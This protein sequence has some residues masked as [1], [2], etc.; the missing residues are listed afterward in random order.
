M[1][2][3]DNIWPKVTLGEFNAIKTIIDQLESERD[4]LKEKLHIANGWGELCKTQEQELQT[5]KDE[6]IIIY[7]D[8]GKEH[9]CWRV[10]KNDDG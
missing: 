6:A 1:K 3:L 7:P 2:E 4:E 8:G 5:L 10:Y 9:A